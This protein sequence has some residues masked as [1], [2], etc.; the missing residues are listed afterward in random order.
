MATPPNCD[1]TD[2]AFICPFAPIS[3]AIFALRANDTFYCLE[4]KA[5]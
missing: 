5:R 4:F 2:L 1:H 3:P